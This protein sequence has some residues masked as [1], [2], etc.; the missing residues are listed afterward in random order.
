LLEGLGGSA[1]QASRIAD[2]R[3]YLEVLAVGAKTFPEDTY[4][5]SESLTMEMDLII[6][7]R[8]TTAMEL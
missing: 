2:Q 5:V 4:T 3:R 6:R 1:A 7:H 8:L